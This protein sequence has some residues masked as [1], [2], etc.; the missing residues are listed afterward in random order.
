MIR[1]LG[2]IGAVP[3]VVGAPE[4]AGGSSLE[5]LAFVQGIDHGDPLGSLEDHAE[6]SGAFDQSVIGCRLTVEE[7]DDEQLDRVHNPFMP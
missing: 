2:G 3:E 4:Q 6:D 5:G 1:L 7:V